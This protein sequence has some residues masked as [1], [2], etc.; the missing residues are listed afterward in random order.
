ME[1]FRPNFTKSLLHLLSN[2]WISDFVGNLG[3]LWD[4]SKGSEK[5][6]I[7]VFM[8]IFKLHNLF[9]QWLTIY[10]ILK[11]NSNS[12]GHVKQIMR[13]TKKIK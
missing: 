8:A 3:Q 11:Y 5:N 6:F 1:F 7:L 13:I 12:K 4:E 10:Y 2:F 9:L